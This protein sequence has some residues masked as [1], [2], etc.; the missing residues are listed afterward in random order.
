MIRRALQIILLLGLA[1]SLCAQKLPVRSYGL[2]DGLS[3]E[4]VHRIVADSRGFVWF[5]TYDGLSRFDGER[6]TNYGIKDGLPVASVED[7]LEARDGTYWIA[8]RGGGVARFDPD[9][10]KKGGTTGALFKIY[11]LGS[12]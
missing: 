9:A 5:C 7:L 6:F 8:T 12:E 11:S 10:R 1:R 2:T 4:N 3:H